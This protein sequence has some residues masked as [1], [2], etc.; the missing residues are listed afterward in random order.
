MANFYD[1]LAAMYHLIFEDWDVSIE[2]QGEQLSKLIHTHWPG[3]SSL[4]D[5]S[6]GIGTQTL[7][8]AKRG[9]RL[10]ASDLS[11]SSI[12]RARR[13]A[14]A[15]DLTISFSVCDMRKVFTHHGPGFDVVISCDNSVPHLLNNEDILAAFE[16]MYFC[17]KP[18]G[19]CL[20]TVRDYQ[21][22]TRGK[23]LVKPYDQ[24]IVSGR[25]YI[26]LQVWDFEGE[27]Y[28]LTLFFTEEDLDSRK[29]HTHVFRTTYYA[30]TIDTLLSLM[31]QARF[32][33]IKCLDNVFYQ[34]V[35]I[36]TKAIH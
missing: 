17:L 1:D 26:G 20:I 8:L 23:N 5:V 28:Q 11:V 34:P 2:R 25:R 19:G 3:A 24:R 4:L 16:Q 33:D 15:R 13:E 32:V 18:G 10:T 35:L 7:A 31:E 21:A 12:E 22:E 27:H 29:V 14:E 9:Y 6:C 30:V 36:G